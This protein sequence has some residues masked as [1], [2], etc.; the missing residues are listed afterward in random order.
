V[1]QNWEFGW[2]AHI[3]LRDLLIMVIVAG[4]WDYLMYFSSLAKR[5]HRFKVRSD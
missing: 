3:V 5:L 1:L 2:V 4:G